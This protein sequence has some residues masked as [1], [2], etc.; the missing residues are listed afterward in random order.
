V[1][2]GEDI[3]A[4]EG[5]FEVEVL[6]DGGRE[7]GLGILCKP[8]PKSFHE[9]NKREPLDPWELYLLQMFRWVIRDGKSF[10]LRGFQ[11]E[12]IGEEKTV[13]LRDGEYNKLAYVIKQP[14]VELYLNDE[15][16]DTVEL[17]G[18]PSM[19][20]VVT[21]TEDEIIIKAVNFA[22]V[23]DDIEITLDCDAA[24]SY[25]VGLLTGKADD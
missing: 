15:L 24:D 12:K 16:I 21:D 23:E 2:L 19:C 17:P 20:S 10:V 8:V 18:Y 4:S 22:D 9:R 7:I 5:R 3:E 25:T 13:R 6:A 1:V 11:A 14:Y